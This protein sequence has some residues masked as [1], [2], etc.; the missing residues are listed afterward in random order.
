MTGLSEKDLIRLETGEMTPDENAVERLMAC[1]HIDK[2]ALLSDKAFSF[3][4]ADT[5]QIHDWENYAWG[6]R[7]EYQQSMEEGK[8]IVKHRA[9]FESVNKMEDGEYKTRICEVLNEMVMTL[10]V[11]SG[12]EFE[13]PSELGAIRRALGE[14][15]NQRKKAPERDEMLARLKGAWLGRIAGCLLGKTV[16]SIK[17]GELHTL[18]KE[19]GNWPMKRYILSTDITED[20][21]KNFV[22]PI[23]TRCF[24]DRI[25]CAPSDDDTNYVCLAQVLV[26]RYGRDFTALDVQ[27][28]WLQYQPKSA[29]CTAERAA[30]VNFVKGFNA[31]VSAVYQNPYREWIGAQIRGDYFG[32]I[33]PGNPAMAAEMAWRDASISHVKNGIYGEMMISAM[34]AEA[35]VEDDILSII[36]SG[37]RQIPEKSRLHKA[38]NEVIDMY[39]KGVLYDEFVCEIYRKYNEDNP[40]DWCHVISNAMIVIAAL[41][42]GKGDF[43]SSI[44]MAVQAGLD[45][46]CNGATVG[47][48]LG[49]RGTDSA[50]PEEWTKPL[51]G[52]LDTEII[53]L[54]RVD[55]QNMAEKTLSHIE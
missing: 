29:Y 27:N 8:D 41:L 12:Y 31:P 24:A 13:E 35:A 14:N 38:V 32:Y 36:Q 55:I 15:R 42:Y 49:M 20:M 9:L 2:A 17:V 44:C 10:P 30:Y 48:I 40:H 53:G 21:K 47:S 34:I 52:K 22:F 46:D 1:F 7:F 23:A 6:V 51:N 45:T 18:L 28:T 5:T 33:N 39:H 16:E 54:G 4:K 25:P 26:D 3:P 43:A 37:L 19:S 50:I 11:R